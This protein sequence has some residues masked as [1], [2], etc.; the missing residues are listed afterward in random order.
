MLI[1]IKS[2]DLQAFTYNSEV[3]PAQCRVVFTVRLRN[4]LY[5]VVWGVK[6]YSLTQ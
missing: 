1:W 5:C 6:L 3:G 2:V 4:D